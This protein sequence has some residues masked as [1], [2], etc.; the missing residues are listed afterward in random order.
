M[1]IWLSRLS[2]MQVLLDIVKKTGASKVYCQGEATYEEAQV[3]R[4]VAS[5][6]KTENAQLKTSW[7]STLFDIDALP[8]KLAD[9]PS[10]HGAWLLSTCAM[11]IPSLRFAWVVSGGKLICAHCKLFC[12]AVISSVL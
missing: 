11:S 4:R 9:L 2:M 6:L 12:S 1:S 3:E 10:T 5:A 7:S 8:F